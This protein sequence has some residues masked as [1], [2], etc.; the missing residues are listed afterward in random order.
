[1][2]DGIDGIGGPT[3]LRDLDPDALARRLRDLTGTHY[4]IDAVRPAATGHVNGTLLLDSR[5]ADLVV[6][7]QSDTIAVFESDPAIEPMVLRGL[8]AGGAPVPAVVAVDPDR[9]TLGSPWFAMER[10]DAAGMPDDAFTGYMVDGWFAEATAGERRQACESF[11]RGLASVHA[12]PVEAFAGFDRGGCASQAIDY[13]RAAVED[14]DPGRVPREHRL[15]DLLVERLP[16]GADDDVTLC[17]GDA[18]L[19]NALVRDADVVAIVDWEIAY[20]GNPAADIGYGINHQGWLTQCAGTRLDGIPAPDE[21]WDLWESLSGRR[22]P[23]PD[24]RYWEA[25]GSMIITIT[26][27]R[28]ITSFLGKPGDPSAEDVNNMLVW[29]EGLFDG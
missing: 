13:L 28:V 16:A 1:V 18:R 15:L 2:A 10:V 23:A 29:S 12:V 27:T 19:A 14:A 3:A 17:M 7:V 4:E 22:V 6:K 9:E 21:T 24:R 8:A 26:A 5:P 20:L 11:V 25:F